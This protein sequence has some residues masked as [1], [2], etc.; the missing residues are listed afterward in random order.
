MATS[1]GT[2][3]NDDGNGSTYGGTQ[4]PKANAPDGYQQPAEADKEITKNTE[5][6]AFDTPG[7]EYDSPD[8][9]GDKKDNAEIAAG[10]NKKESSGEE[11]GSPVR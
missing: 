5:Q 4:T 3:T 1:K 7:G 10:D 9:A 8:D 2:A 11:E 6:P